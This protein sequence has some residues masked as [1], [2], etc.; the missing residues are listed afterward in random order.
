MTTRPEKGDPAP[1]LVLPCVPGDEVTLGSGERGQVIFFYPKDNTPGCTNEAKDFSALKPQFEPL[2]FDVIGVSKD[3]L[4]KHENFINKQ[5]L[6]VTLASDADHDACETYGVWVEKKMYGKV[7]LGIERS[8]F[9]IGADGKILECW[10]KVK[11][12]G[13]AQEVLDAIG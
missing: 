1:Q 2:G 5:G 9:L 13:H 4:K 3:S 6:S 12:K 7:F 8:T 11:V 10:R